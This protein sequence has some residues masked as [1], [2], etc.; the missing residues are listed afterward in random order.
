MSD[1]RDSK[2]ISRRK[3]LKATAWVLTLLPLLLVGNLIRKRMKVIQA[4]RKGSEIP[5]DIQDGVHLFPDVIVNRQGDSLL[6]LST[7]CPHLGCRIDTYREGQLMCPCHG[8]RFDREGNLLEGPATR[9]LE[10][11]G[12]T[13]DPEKGVF[14]VEPPA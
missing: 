10:R 4:S 5:L 7:R 13:K 3:V 12:F 9:G 11:L 14:I 2:Q 6:F 8:S 1:T